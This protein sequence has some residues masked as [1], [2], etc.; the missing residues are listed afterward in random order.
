MNVNGLAGGIELSLGRDALVNA[1]GNL[2]IES[3]RPLT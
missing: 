3:T 1:G 2:G